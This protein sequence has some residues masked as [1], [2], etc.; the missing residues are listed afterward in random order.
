MLAL[1]RGGKDEKTA[2]R[3]LRL[4]KRAD[5]KPLFAL[6]KNVLYGN[7]HVSK[8]CLKDLKPFKSELIDLSD[9][10]VKFDK[11]LKILKHWPLLRLLLRLAELVYFAESDTS[12][13]EGE[14]SSSDVE[15]D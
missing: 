10:F 1:A 14:S 4:A 9:R 15:S 3:L 5:L 11:K 12:S 2:L 7:V 13:S 6:V 8:R